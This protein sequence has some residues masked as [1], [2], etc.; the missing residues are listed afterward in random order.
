ML[1]NLEYKSMVEAAEKGEIL[2]GVDRALA[3]KLFTETKNRFREFES[4]INES[5]R[6]QR[7]ISLI[8]FVSS[9]ILV[10][11]TSILAIIALGW[12]ALLGV[13]IIFFI[14]LY[15]KSLSVRGGAGLKAISFFVIFAILIFVANPF[16]WNIQYLFLLPFIISL[17][18]ERFL[19][20]YTT[21]QLRTLVLRNKKAYELFKNGI[22][23]RN[24]LSL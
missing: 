3:R 14:W 9:P 22:I 20:C 10:L 16:L 2:V 18:L 23:I 21:H 17:W 13:P 15:Y 5:L 6:L 12:W 1:S 8:A 7:A 11:L 24:V 19:Y 4:I